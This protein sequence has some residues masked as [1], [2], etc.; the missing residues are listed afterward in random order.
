M[1]TEIT[2]IAI[3]SL[4][5]AAGGAMAGGSRSGEAQEKN[6]YALSMKKPQVR[7]YYFRPGGHRYDFE[8]QPFLRWNG[9]YGN[10]P[11][12]DP[13]SFKERVFSDPRQPTTSPSAF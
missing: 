6:N 12:F 4:S 11:E 7:G 5:L 9:P 3:L 10:F 2:I 8:Y 1:K 13:R